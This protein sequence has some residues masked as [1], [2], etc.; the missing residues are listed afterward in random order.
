M[1]D[2]YFAERMADLTE[3][4]NKPKGD[5]LISKMAN[6]IREFLSIIKQ[7]VSKDVYDNFYNAVMSIFYKGYFYRV[8][9]CV[10]LLSLWPLHIP[11]P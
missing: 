2:E 11:R 1:L 7:S 9:Y 5:T 8:K 4:K 3:S 10:T 6:L